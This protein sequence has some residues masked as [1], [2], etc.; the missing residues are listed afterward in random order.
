MSL[1]VAAQ[2]L[3]T[4]KALTGRTSAGLNVHDS[5][6]DPLALMSG[7]WAPLIVV[8]CDAGRRTLRD[9]DL[10]AATQV[11]DLTVDM[12]VARAV[13]LSSGE[14]DVVLP[15][16]DAGH[17]TYLRSLAYEIEKVLI[18]DPGPWAALWRSLWVRGAAQEAMQWERGADARD[19]ERIAFLR[20]IYRLELLAD[21]VPGAPLA[22][23]WERV[24]AAM[25]ADDELV[26]IG[27]YW[28]SLITSPEQ[29][30]WRQ[31]MGA[32]GI[33]GSSVQGIGIGPVVAD[34]TPADDPAPA[35]EITVD[36]ADIVFTVPDAG[37]QS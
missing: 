34:P 27:A 10:L 16:T 11:V 18:T 21:P 5:V 35:A 25:E 17:V 9:R 28:R 32:L 37:V 31:A 19:G 6:I 23:V 14:A 13:N 8:H 1:V 29:P 24:I 20:Q 7:D 15:D 2:R 30:S 4:V 26:G 22:G 36:A 12:F 33:S 3:A